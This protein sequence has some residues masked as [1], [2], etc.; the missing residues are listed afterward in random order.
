METLCNLLEKLL[1][2]TSTGGN[3]EARQRKRKSSGEGRIEYV[4]YDNRT[5]LLITSK[6]YIHIIKSGA[7]QVVPHCLASFL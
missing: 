7:A 1:Q 5:H 4:C 6:K 3:L 2:S